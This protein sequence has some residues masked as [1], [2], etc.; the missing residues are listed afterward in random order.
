MSWL[1]FD[2]PSGISGD[3]TL[4]ALVD[5]G[6]PLDTIAEALRSLPL[7]GYRLRRSQVTRNSIAAM[8][9]HVEVDGETRHHHRHL[10][11]VIEI[12]E[13]GTLPRRARGWAVAV[14]R[15]L[16]EAEAAAHRVPVGQVHFHEVGAVDAIV[17]IAGTCV[18][19][20]LLCEM[21]GVRTFRTSQ[22][23]VGRGSVRT[24][25]GVMPVPPPATLRLLEGFPV[26][27]GDS[28]GERVTPTGAA[29]LSALTRPLAGAPIRVR[30]T[31]YGAGSREFADAPN[32]LRLLLCEPE[33]AAEHEDLPDWET[34][35]PTSGTRRFPGAADV[36]A[37]GA[38]TA[39]SDAASSSAAAASSVSPDAPGRVSEPTRPAAGEGAKP[40]RVGVLATTID[41]MVPEFY[42]HLMARLFAEGA[43]D[44]FYTPIHMKKDRPATQVTV[45][46]EPEDAHRLADVLLNESSTLGVRIA[47]EER[48]ELPRR[49]KTVRTEY[50]EIRVKVA[51][52]PDGKLRSVPEYESVRRAAEAA[53][54]PIADVY[55]AALRVEGVGDVDAAEPSS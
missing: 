52:R 51:L 40:G 42:G 29:I 2:C 22:I 5:L 16:A 3:M 48:V 28:E 45:I 37:E 32:V 41:D 12:L 7:E 31:G 55:G 24:E 6:L 23:R 4:G 35:L 10:H 50:G 43:L 30:A 14:F 1:V 47:Y 15:E 8:R 38:G 46:A 53:G 33:R 17:D 25:H 19:L 11:D 13:S 54:V 36:R 21:H 27:F 44:V 34:P 9:V 39:G 49:L 20:H 26:Q 18:G